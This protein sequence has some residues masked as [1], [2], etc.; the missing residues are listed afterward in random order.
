MC[1]H[2]FHFPQTHGVM[3]ESP[4]R[5]SCKR[6]YFLELFLAYS[7]VKAGCLF[8]SHTFLVRMTTDGSNW[9]IYILKMCSRNRL[10]AWL[11]LL[12]PRLH[13][14]LFLLFSAF[15][16]CTCAHVTCS[17]SCCERSSS[18]TSFFFYV[19]FFCVFAVLYEILWLCFCYPKS[20][21]YFY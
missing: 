8:D 20:M 10:S 17:C 15:G 4:D 1:G 16:L 21:I 18:R 19:H 5:L 9:S 2:E 12:N 6:V 7:A 14:I 3:Y 11:Y 13:H